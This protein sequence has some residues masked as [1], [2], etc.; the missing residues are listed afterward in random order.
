[1][2]QID[3]G[4]HFLN[5]IIER[6]Y[7]PG[8]RLPSIAELAGEEH[9][10]ISTSKVREQLE[11]ARALGLVEVRS[12][13]GTRLKEYTFTPAVSLSLLF[14]LAGEFSKFEMFGSLRIHLE[15]AYWH[16]GCALL[17]DDDIA[18]MQRCIEAANEK[19]N[20]HPIRIPTYEHRGFHLAVFRR[21]ENPFVLGLLE[22]Y[23]DAY[24]AVIPTRYVAYDYLKSVWDYHQQIL[25]AIC[26]QDIDRAQQLFIEHTRLL[27]Y[28]DSHLRRDEKEEE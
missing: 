26:A 1:M 6:G 19:L 10:S 8:D 22:A 5:Y 17:Q 27:Q 21:L 9:L 25:E 3:L 14:A 13:T 24:E 12:K 7:Q 28:P 16:E 11:V 4:S 2:G 18:Q 15:V 23:W 20:A